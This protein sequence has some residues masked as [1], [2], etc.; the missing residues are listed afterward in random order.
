MSLFRGRFNVCE[1]SIKDSSAY[2]RLSKF[3]IH[4]ETL[5]RNIESLNPLELQKMQTSMISSCN[6]VINSHQG[7]DDLQ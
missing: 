2:L 5:A 3:T 6:T 7:L 1:T 4:A